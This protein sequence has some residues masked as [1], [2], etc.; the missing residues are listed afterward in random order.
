MCTL[1]TLPVLL[2]WLGVGL[3]LMLCACRPTHLQLPRR[4]AGLGWVQCMMWENALG[5]PDGDYELVMS[6]QGPDCRH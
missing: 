1:A 4:D 2:L 3:D 6:R 5:C